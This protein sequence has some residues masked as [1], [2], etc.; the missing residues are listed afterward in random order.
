MP[1]TNPTP[2]EAGVESLR[3]ADLLPFHELLDADM[4][5]EAL[6]AEKFRF[7]RCI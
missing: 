4:V 5:D 1:Q 2:L 3:E 7:N 6:K